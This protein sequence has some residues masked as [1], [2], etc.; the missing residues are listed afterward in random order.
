MIEARLPTKTGFY[1]NNEIV[2]IGS[3]EGVVFEPAICCQFHL[4]NQVVS[5]IVEV[6]PSGLSKV[7]IFKDEHEE[8]HR[9]LNNKRVVL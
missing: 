9:C 6:A 5:S 4:P 3:D 7:K 2:W 8:E 1:T